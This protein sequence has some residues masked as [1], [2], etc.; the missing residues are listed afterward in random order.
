MPAVVDDEKGIFIL[1]IF[2]KAQYFVIELAMRILG[3][4][5]KLVC[6]EAV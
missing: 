4:D 6:R 1:M 3:W 5:E 2:H